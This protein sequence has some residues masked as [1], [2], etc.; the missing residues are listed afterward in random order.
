MTNIL[1]F[2]AYV[3][4]AIRFMAKVREV[5]HPSTHPAIRR[6][7]QKRLKGSYLFLGLAISAVSLLSAGL[8]LA[9]W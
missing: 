2:L 1:T 6:A 8:T 3:I 4:Y 9:M 5:E 7:I